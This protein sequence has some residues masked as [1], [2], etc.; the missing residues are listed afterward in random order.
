MQTELHK[1]LFGKIKSK[2]NEEVRVKDLKVFLSYC[3]IECSIT[4]K[5]INE[6]EKMNLL[7]KENRYSIKL[8]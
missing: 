4:N 1:Y 2:F 7:K 5:I 8:N 3:R 6:M